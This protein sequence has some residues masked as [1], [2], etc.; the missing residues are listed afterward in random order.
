LKAGASGANIVNNGGS[1]GTFG[2]NLSSDNGVGVLTNSTDQLNKDP[3][4]GPLADNGGPTLTHALLPGSP[5]IDKGKSF[6]ATT[7][8]RGQPRPFD[9]ASVTNAAG[10]DGSD[11]GAFELN[12]QARFISITALADRQ[13]Q[14]QGAGLSNFTYSIQANTNLA[15]T[16]WALIGN[17]TANGSG[18][19]SFT[20]TNAPSLPMRFYR[21][22][23]P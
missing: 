4:L 10:G 6:G 21:V 9:F 19:F 5:A 12:P 18:I 13:I 15:V 3:L 2:Y 11:I 17:A 22:L 20:D 16:N 7:D 23:F 8:Q 14:L 1:V